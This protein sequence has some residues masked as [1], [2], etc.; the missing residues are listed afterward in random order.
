LLVIPGIILIVGWGVAVPACVQEDLRPIQALSRSWYLTKG[1]FWRLFGVV[2]IGLIF[3]LLWS[4]GVDGI[5]G[6]ILTVWAEEDHV[7][8]VVE[9]IIAPWADIPLTLAAIAAYYQ[10]VEI[11]E[12]K[13]EPEIADVFE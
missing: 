4:T 12:G 8:W 13:Q 5:L 2:A 7:D 3:S 1:N 9:S 6:A 11:K 10:L